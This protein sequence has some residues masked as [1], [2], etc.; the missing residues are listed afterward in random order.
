LKIA[1]LSFATVLNATASWQLET[2]DTDTDELLRHIVKHS[3]GNLI[4][5]GDDN[6]IKVSQNDGKNWEEAEIPDVSGFGESDDISIRNV[7]E[8]PNSHELLALGVI[9]KKHQ[10]GP[11][12]VAGGPSWHT[13]RIE[14]WT[15]VLISSDG[16]RTWQ[17]RDKVDD[18]ALYW[19]LLFSDGQCI[20]FGY[21]E[22]I[23]E[24]RN[25]KAVAIANNSLSSENS[26][27][28]VSIPFAGQVI[29]NEKRKLIQYGDY[30]FAIEER[31]AIGMSLDRGRTWS[32]LQ[33][34]DR[35]EKIN[36]IAV[37]DEQ[38]MIG[39][40]DNGF[41]A[42]SEDA[43]ISWNKKKIAENDLNAVFASSMCDWWV[44]G[45]DG[46]VAHSQNSGKSWI[47]LESESDEDL[48]F[49]LLYENCDEGWILGKEGTL[50]RVFDK[51]KGNSILLE[52]PSKQ[53]VSWS[54]RA[55][56]NVQQWYESVNNPSELSQ[57]LV[58]TVKPS[59]SRV[60]IGEH[61]YNGG[62]L[63]VALPPGKHYLLVS[64]NGYFTEEDG[65]EIDIGSVE[66]EAITLRPIKI[67][68][69]PSGAMIASLSDLGMLFSIQGGILGNKKNS[70]GLLLDAGIF[71]ANEISIVD[72]C[73]YYSHR[74]DLGK[75]F[76]LSPFLAAGGI[77]IQEVSDSVY[78]DTSYSPARPDTIDDGHKAIF[79]D[80]AL[81]A[82][83]DVNIRKNQN[84]GFSI[85]PSL[86]WTRRLGYQFI[87][88]FGAIFWIL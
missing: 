63:Q 66:E 84:W 33:S 79:Y 75:Y 62:N 51:Q 34:K 35:I 86:L 87:M 69:S 21:S 67:V 39:V 15:A 57:G 27:H 88:R 49:L 4:I 83:I 80:V 13:T 61:S 25:G 44:V 46:Y 22:N 81:Q 24:Y 82:G 8:L 68:I 78:F 47:A 53:S 30:L 45:D 71:V 52:K 42:I 41:I 59:D 32:I 73:P 60:Q 11:I 26:Q 16:G 70:V 72:L 5:V 76:H 85:K 7:I 14:K 40:C 37:I 74:F 17:I 28:R 65:I 36:A 54:S 64:K 29:V 38:S 20:L 10:S 6:T 58:L 9:D 55:S 48:T 56:D 43:G 23:Y 2:I 1:L 77:F 50:I 12:G 19:P 3:S 18:A 31:T